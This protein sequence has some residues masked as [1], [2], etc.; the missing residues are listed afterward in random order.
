M[1]SRYH[2]IEDGLWDDPKFDAHG[3]IP[4][5]TGD[6]RGFFAFLASNK[7]QRASGLYR[8]TDSELS[9]AYRWPVKRV[10]ATLADLC[11]RGLVVRDGA[12]IFLPGYFK[13]Q[14]HNPSVLKSAKN[15]LE[16]CTSNRVMASFCEH[17]PLLNSWCLHHGVTVETPETKCSLS[18]QSSTNTEQSSTNTTQHRAGETPTDPDEHQDSSAPQWGTPEALVQFYNEATP[19]EFS[20]CTRLTPDRIKGATAI[21]ETFPERVFW[22][23]VFKLC[24]T[25]PFLRGQVTPTNGHK[26]FQATFDWFLAKDPTKN[27]EN[28][29][30]V[31]EGFY[32]GTR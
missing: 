30:K 10:T 22:E 11:R 20:A 31:R 17:Y 24:H 19:E 23:S 13:R 29:L 6:T 4:E 7:M 32:N 5:A 14:A 12:W 1:P 27:T 25:S 3:L 8:A 26:R 28:A 15:S 16:S 2:P 9:A 21:L 18:E